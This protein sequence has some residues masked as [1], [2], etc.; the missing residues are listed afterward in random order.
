M[1][2]PEVY[3][4]EENLISS[5][6]GEDPPPLHYVPNDTVSITHSHLRQLFLFA[7]MH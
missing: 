1:P 7:I 3:V 4:W 6:F 5:D 2:I